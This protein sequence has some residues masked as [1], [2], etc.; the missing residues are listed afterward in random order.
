MNAGIFNE[1]T[2]VAEPGR[3]GTAVGARRDAVRQRRGRSAGFTLIE[4]MVASALLIVG[5]TAMAH[6]MITA[7]KTAAMAERQLD[8]MH[9]AR[10]ALE[11]LGTFS[12]DSSALAAGTHTLAGNI[13]VYTVS[14]VDSL[15]K[16]IVMSVFW[17]DPVRA[18]SNVVTLTTSFSRTLHP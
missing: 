16:D 17:N 9:T 2:G 10:A 11:E 1:S 18:G 6:T 5:L 14:S 15:T 4:A 8:A 3:T 7:N 13:G 12:F